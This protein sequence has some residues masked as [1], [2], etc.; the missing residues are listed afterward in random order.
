MLHDAKERN[1]PEIRR[2]GRIEHREL[3]L[4]VSDHE[5]CGEVA[6]RST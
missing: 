3:H 5:G 4:S 2:N 1:N 6:T